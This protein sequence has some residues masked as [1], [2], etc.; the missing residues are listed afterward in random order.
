MAL[1][2]ATAATAF[3]VG[4]VAPAGAEAAAHFSESVV[5]DRI[6]CATRTYTITA[7]VIEATIQEA[8]N[9]AGGAEFHGTFA[10][11]GVEAT[12]DDG[13]I[14][15]A[16]GVQRFGATFASGD[17][18]F[19][20]IELNRIVLVERQHGAVDAVRLAVRVNAGGDIVVDAGTCAEPG[21]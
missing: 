11:I 9:R 21:S 8:E 16:H 12:S 18:A 17:G 19:K 15:A 13:T 14:V 6:V 20:L 2:A 10:L 4:E 5:G 7:G 3:S 1:A